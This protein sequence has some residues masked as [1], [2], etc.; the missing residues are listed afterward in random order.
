MVEILFQRDTEL[1]PP[2]NILFVARLKAGIYKTRT[3]TQ[4]HACKH[5]HNP[6]N[7]QNILLGPKRFREPL[8]SD[9]DKKKVFAV[10]RC[11]LDPILLIQTASTS[12]T[13]SYR[14]DKRVPRNFV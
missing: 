12:E 13:Q 14:R 6:S 7:R 2:I 10:Y 8:C 9:H 3:D 1:Y 11:E 5:R 4:V